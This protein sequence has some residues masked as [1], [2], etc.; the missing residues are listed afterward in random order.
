MKTFKLALLAISFSLGSFQTFADQ[1]NLVQDLRIQLYG[2][3]QGGTTT[4]GNF[5]TTA[6]NWVTLDTR[7]ILAALGATTS[8]SFSRASRLVLVTPQDGSAQAVQ[9]RDGSTTVDVTA[10]FAVNQAVAGPV[11]S[12]FLD[13]RRGRSFGAQY[14]LQHFALQDVQDGASVSLHFDVSGFGVQNL[15]T[16]GSYL[17]VN[18]SGTGDS[19]GTSLIIEGSISLNGGTLEVVAGGGG[20]ITS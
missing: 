9:V 2:V 8:N 15:M 17:N 6:A 12:S 18:V 19:S 13:T 1:T 11:V 16:R 10:F 14:S 5:V 7:H 3:S 20:V 4:N